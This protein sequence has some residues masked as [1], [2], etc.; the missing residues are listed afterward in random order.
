[1][2]VSHTVLQISF[3]HL[4]C[5]SLP[6]S[7][8]DVL[9]SSMALVLRQFRE[10]RLR[11]TDDA[12]PLPRLSHFALVGRF[13]FKHAEVEVYLPRALHERELFHE[14]SSPNGCSIID[15]LPTL[16]CF[17][18]SFTGKPKCAMTF[19][20]VS[21]ISLSLCLVKFRDCVVANMVR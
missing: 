10:K 14:L 15:F 13:H 11:V 1:M 20:I 6:T 17:K 7:L 19:F 5:R 9:V 21:M 16:T 4:A 18:Q 12:R 2:T 3:V 8:C